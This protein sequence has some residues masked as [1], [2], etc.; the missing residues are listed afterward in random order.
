MKRRQAIT[1][2]ILIGVVAAGALLWLWA[3][4][5]NAEGRVLARGI[6]AMQQNDVNQAAGLFREA[7][8]RYPRSYPA[9]YWLAVAELRLGQT[10]EARRTAQEASQLAPQKPEPWVVRAAAFRFDANRKLDALARV[11]SETEF[12]AAEALC[13]EALAALEQAEQI[14]GSKENADVLAERGLCRR[15]MADLYRWREKTAQAE[16]DR[17]AGTDATRAAALRKESEAAGQK[18]REAAEQGLASLVASLRSRPDNARAAE[19]AQDLAMDLG[20]YE[21]VL[22]AYEQL[23]AAKAVSERA[24]IQAA[25]SLISRAAAP[26]MADDWKASQRAVEILNAYIEGHPKSR[27]IDARVLLARALLMRG[28]RQAAAA[29]VDRVLELE[30]NNAWGR[31]VRAQLL[32]ADGKPEEAKQILQP[33]GTVMRDYVPYKL[34]MAAVQRQTGYPQVER[35]L[36]REVLDLEP[37]NADAHLALIGAMLAEGQT[38]PAETQLAAA[39]N[40]APTNERIVRFAVEYWLDRG[41]GKQALEV[42]DRVAR[43]PN[44]PI[45]LRETVADLYVRVGRP[46]EAERILRQLGPGEAS[47]AGVRQKA[48]LAKLAIARGRISEGRRAFEEL[49][50]ANPKWAPGRIELAGALVRENRCEEA[51]RAAREALALDSRDIAIQ[52]AAAE[53][54]AGCGLLEDAQSLCEKV[55]LQAPNNQAALALAA[56]IDLLRQDYDSAGKRYEALN[57]MT[58]QKVQDWNIQAQLALREGRYDKCIEICGDKND[59]VAMWMTAEALSRLGRHEDAARKLAS[60]IETYPDF[61]QAYDRLVQIWLAIDT[62]AGALERLQTLKN[63]RPLPLALSKGAILAAM[64]KIDDSIA[65]Y[66]AI[67][68]DEAIAS[69]PGAVVALRDALATCYRAKKDPVNELKQFEA[70]A[71]AK[72]TRLD[73]ETRMYRFYLRQNRLD[74]AAEVL[75]RVSRGAG[76]EEG[77]IPLRLRLASAYLAIGQADKAIGELNRAIGARPDL[78]QLVERKVRAY[79]AASKAD[80][81]LSTVTD[82]LKRWPDEISLLRALVDVQAARR[83]YPGALSALDRM[84]LGG[85]TARLESRYARAALFVRM[86][87]YADA[88]E[89]LRS[90]TQT[91]SAGTDRYALTIAQALIGLGQHDEGRA[92]LAKIPASS[93]YHRSAQHLLA[94]DLRGAGKRDEAIKVLQ[95]LVESGPDEGGVAYE[96][97][98]A[99]TQAGRYDEAAKVARSQ[100]ARFAPRTSQAT[101]W[102]TALATISAKK[103]DWPGAIEA[104]QEVVNTFPQQR[105]FRWQLA[106]YQLAAGQIE[107]AAEVLADEP[108]D[109]LLATV[110]RSLVAGQAGSRPAAAAQPGALEQT[111]ADPRSSENTR[112][113]YLLTT[114]AGRSDPQG[115]L[116][117]LD[118]VNTPLA[119]LARAYLASPSAGN[120][121]A[122]QACALLAQAMIARVYGMVPLADYFCE[123]ADKLD[124]GSPLIAPVWL[125]VLAQ[126]N[127]REQAA[128]VSAAG[129]AAL[130]KTRWALEVSVWEAMA[131]NDNDAVIR[132]IQEA[133]KAGPV[134]TAMLTAAGAGLMKQG[135]LTEALQR[136]EQA[137]AA[138]PDDAD[139]NNNVAYLLAEVKADDPAA[140][141][142]AMTLIEKSLSRKPDDPGILETRGWIRVRRGE[143]QAALADFTRVIEALR[144]DPRVHYHLGVCYQ[145]L[146]QNEMARLHLANVARLG[147]ADLPEAKLA[148][149]LLKTLPATTRPA[150]SAPVAAAR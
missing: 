133:E 117:A 36:Y 94:T 142:R 86:G 26:V 116:K 100:I 136:F 112:L 13:G 51:V 140:L 121:K 24:A 144:N 61:G 119:D 43:S 15:T 148:N 69:K 6:I 125:P 77:A 146:G 67:L 40:A 25:Q 128:K 72:E 93:P 23:A 11:P 141:D 71:A 39:L 84:A 129:R 64:G 88:I 143:A 28:E 55:L 46:D 63:A 41:R 1:W 9:A 59:S 90:L 82:A 131:A 52:L 18:R 96:L 122:R 12:L 147:G 106:L 134:S 54:L 2:L 101:N 31:L 110:V 98:D 92:E 83:D 104:M 76:D 137:L 70:L 85:E 109:S 38:G 4:H 62:P 44:P 81:A 105:A 32:L 78:P 118:G 33:L 73:G 123:Q 37:G 74:Q 135:R 114:L 20:K 108:A 49:V 89:V 111:I 48:V 102:K 145:K 10:D 65:I 75:D 16:A 124:A 45:G 138:E 130:G 34:T 30:P 21:V 8:R 57:A 47:G 87:L 97:A 80:D 60:L 115:V 5:R 95:A 29:V 103:R 120:E 126:L 66:N 139:T 27:C 50:A 107:P 19:A 150:T 91:E 149:E 3:R 17:L 53:V 7:R 14:A 113:T 127:K 79:L 56:R 99:L 22:E 42:L 58:G 132:K 35:Q 68:A